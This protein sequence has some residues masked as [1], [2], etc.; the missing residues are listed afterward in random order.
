M[1][2]KLEFAGRNDHTIWATGENMT[3]GAVPDVG[4]VPQPDPA[5]LA[6]LKYYAGLYLKSQHGGKQR[7][8]VLDQGRAYRPA[9]RTQLPTIAAVPACKLSADK[10]DYGNSSVFV[11]SG[12][13]SYGVTLGTGSGRLMSQMI[14]NDKTDLDISKFSLVN[15]YDSMTCQIYS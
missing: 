13:G 5:S 3:T 10:R 1:G 15:N 8:R 12:H 2:H 9:T 4:Q 6:K 11:N 7:M 14:L